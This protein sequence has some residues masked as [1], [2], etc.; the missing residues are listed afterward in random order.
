MDCL[1]NQPLGGRPT[2]CNSPE[3]EKII[4][5]FDLNTFK[6]SL[7]GLILFY[8]W[9]MDATNVTSGASVN[10]AKFL[11]NKLYKKK[12]DPQSKNY[13][14]NETFINRAWSDFKP[15]S[16]L[17]AAYMIWVICGAGPLHKLLTP[18]I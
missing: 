1:F 9:R 5:L 17:W 18:I 14:F 8:I 2:L 10:K 15:V 6:G 4:E 7:A 3:Y 16:H 11:V 13:T 12:R